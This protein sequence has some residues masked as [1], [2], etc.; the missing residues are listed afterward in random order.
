MAQTKRSA[1]VSTLWRNLPSLS[2]LRAFDATARH[3]GFAGAARVLNV[4][5]AAVTQQVRGLE[6]ELGVPLVRRAGRTVS[7]TEAG[8]RWRAA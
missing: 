1:Y 5:H 8:Q 7:L 2:A 4:T 6:R 3:G